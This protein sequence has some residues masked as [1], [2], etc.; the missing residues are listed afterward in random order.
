MED[1][2]P[3]HEMVHIRN[4]VKSHLVIFQHSSKKLCAETIDELSL[5]V[6]ETIDFLMK[7]SSTDMK[8][9]FIKCL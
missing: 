9:P 4:I 3:D 8:R 2:M 6:T 5:K 1:Y 7:K